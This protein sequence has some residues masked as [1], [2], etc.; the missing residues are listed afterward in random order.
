[1]GWTGP[2]HAEGRPGWVGPPVSRGS[3][4]RHQSAGPRPGG[5][6]VARVAAPWP[7][8]TGHRAD[9]TIPHRSRSTSPRRRRPGGAARTV[10]HGVCNL[11]DRPARGPNRPFGAPPDGPLRTVR[12]RAWGIRPA[13]R[14]TRG[15]HA[16]TP[17]RSRL[18][19]AGRTARVR[20]VRRQAL[21]T[22]RHRRSRRSDTRNAGPRPSAAAPPGWRAAAAPPGGTT[23]D[24]PRAGADS[25]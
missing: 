5:T 23:P 16:K 15:N 21:W 12:S 3:E 6:V 8:G 14:R 20:S 18:V 25:G 7:W 17:E 13:A 1:M 4:R 11:V 9:D 10:G 19:A 2:V 22:M 24:T